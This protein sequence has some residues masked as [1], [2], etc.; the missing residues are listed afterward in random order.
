MMAEPVVPTFGTVV[1]RAPTRGV[2]ASF[3]TMRRVSSEGRAAFLA[4]AS[5]LVFT[6]N[7]TPPARI[8]WSEALSL[9]GWP[10]EPVR[11]LL[12]RH[13]MRATVG[14]WRAAPARVEAPF[15]ALT[16]DV[17]AALAVP[18]GGE[19]GREH[20]VFM[21]C[22]LTEEGGFHRRGESRG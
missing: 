15:A 9:V 16:D 18:C 13:I 7:R 19:E 21:T 8:A 5:F 2:G 20:E 22:R 11:A 6:S 14:A 12:L 1:G 4:R 17:G 10:R 3:P